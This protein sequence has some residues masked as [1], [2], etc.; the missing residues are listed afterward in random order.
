ME[1]MRL[2]ALLAIVTASSGPT[3]A[4]TG[5]PNSATTTPVRAPRTAIE[6][7]LL[8]LADPA[9]RHA[10]MLALWQ[11]GSPAVP[12]LAAVIARDD[13][14]AAS[15]LRVLDQLG[16]EAAPAAPVL[17]RAMDKAKEPWRSELARTIARIEGPPCILV[18]LHEKNEVV[19]VDFDGKVVRRAPC[20]SPWGVWPMPEDHFGAISFN[21]GMVQQID[22]SGEVKDS[23]K[24]IHSITSYLPLDDG[25][26]ITTNWDG[27]GVLARRGADGTVSWS[28]KNDAYRSMRLFD[29]VLAVARKPPRLITYSLTGEELRAIDL[30]TPCCGLYPLPNGNVMLSAHSGQV[31]E[32]DSAGKVVGELK[33]EGFANDVARLRDGRTVVSGVGG[34]YLFAKDGS[35]LWHLTDLSKCGPMFVRVPW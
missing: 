29:E 12:M 16:G 10:A 5:E 22:W 30:P 1:T 8:A 32:V 35:T 20:Q 18:S 4:Q 23:L 14:G 34:L 17:H 24:V 27:D 25:G 3:T 13:A 9:Q 33:V 31:L 28:H 21:Q 11:S 26:C 15:A 7:N 2:L 19:Q 6:R